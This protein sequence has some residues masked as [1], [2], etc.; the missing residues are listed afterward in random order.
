MQ[1]KRLSCFMENPFN[2][3]FNRLNTIQQ[4]IQYINY[5]S[6]PKYFDQRGGTLLRITSKNICNLVMKMNDKLLNK[7]IDIAS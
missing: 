4:H 7:L 1:T 5:T 3:Q 6:D 2:K